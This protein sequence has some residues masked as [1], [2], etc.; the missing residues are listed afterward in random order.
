MLPWIWTVILRNMIYSYT[1]SLCLSINLILACRSP[2][3]STHAISL[4]RLPNLSAYCYTKYLYLL[5]LKVLY[6]QEKMSAIFYK[7]VNFRD[8]LLAF[9]QIT[10]LLKRWSTLK[11]KN[12]LQGSKFF[13]FRVDLFPDGRQNNF[14]RVT[15][16]WNASVVLKQILACGNLI[17]F[18]HA[19]SLS[20]LPKLLS[21]CY[22]THLL[23]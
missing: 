23:L 6:T 17:S 9:L 5:R 1:K 13:P 11:G 20:A 21:Y 2:I 16:S 22:I 7:G 18:D 3:F 19:I 10:P 4:S 15:S 8:F 12:L 14:E